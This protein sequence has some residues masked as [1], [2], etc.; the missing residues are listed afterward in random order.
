MTNRRLFLGAALASFALVACDSKTETL[1]PKYQ[2]PS[3]AYQKN[4]PEVPTDWDA[5]H[6]YTEFMES[7]EGVH[8]PGPAGRPMAFIVFDTQ[9][10][11]CLRLLD[12]TMPLKDKI[13]FVWVPVAVLNPHSEPQGAAIL[14]SLNRV[15]MFERHH[16]QFSN[17]PVRGIDTE[18]MIIPFDKRQAVWTNTRIFRLT[19]GREVPFGVMKDKD[20]NFH[21][22]L[23]GMKTTDIEKLFDL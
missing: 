8:F 23:S 4:M 22:I 12:Q 21:P 14:S 18:N 9:C 16:A 2:T 3:S 7:A 20:G 5:E 6:M 19:G 10:S 1:Q 11:Y 17:Q 15:E 13:D